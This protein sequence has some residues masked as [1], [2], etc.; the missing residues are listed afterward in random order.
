MKIMQLVRV[1]VPIVLL[2]SG[3]AQAASRQR[4]GMHRPASAT[5]APFVGTLPATTNLD[6]AIGLPLRN[7]EALSELLQGICDPASPLYRQ[8][9][10]PAQFTDRFGPTREDYDAVIAFARAH[11]LTVTATHP[12]RMLLDVRGSVADINNAFHVTL[13]LRRHPTEPRIFFAPDVMPSV[14]LGVP[15]LDVSGLENYALPRPRH[16]ASLLT[17]RTGTS[18]STGSGPYGSYMGEDF[19]AAYVPGSPF[20]G[21]GQIAGLLEFDGYSPAD[22]AYY[23]NKAGL[24]SVTLSNVLLNGVSGNPSGGGGEIEVCLD[25]ELIISMAPGISQLVVYEGANW[26]DILN[27]MAT[28]NVA[29]QISC[30][31]YA[32]NS[33]PD[34]VAD[35][36]WRQMALQGQSFYSASGD[37]DACTGPI[38]F[39]DDSPY[40]TEV[41]GTTLTTASGAYV[42]EKAWNQGNGTGTGG[43]I[44]TSYA[45]PYYQTNI[46]MTTNLGSAVMRNTPDVA[47]VAD[48]LYIRADGEDYSAEGTSASAPLWAGLTALINQLAL[49]NGEPFVGFVNPAVYALG[50]GGRYTSCFHDITVG[51]NQRTGSGA[52]F[53]AT[54]GY[55]LCTGWGTPVGEN[56][57]YALGFPEP[58]HIMPATGGMFT[59][60]VGGPF[61][62]ASQALS[63]TNYAGGSLNWTAG[64]PSLWLNV[65][66]SNGVL[67]AGGPAQTV[68]ITLAPAAT[69]LAAG[70]YQATL[71]FTNQNT[72]FVQSQPVT[73]AVVT[74]PLIVSQP[75]SLALLEG[76]TAI[77]TAGTASN[78]LLNFQWQQD[79]GSVVTNLTD[80]GRISG[81]ASNTLVVS[82]TSPTDQGA[83]SVI[84]SNAAGVA[85]SD[86]AYLAILPWRPVIT[87]QPAGQTV[88][89]G[90]PAAF[91][92]AAVGTHP[93]SYCWQF[94]GTNLSDNANLSGSA[95][96]TLKILATTAAS[97][98][99]Y[100][101]IVS[102][103]LGSTT[104]TAAVL[105]LIPVTGPG[106]NL[107][108]LYSFTN[109]VS[110]AAPYSALVQALDGNFYGTTSQGGANNYG[111]VFRMTPSDTFTT[112]HSFNS[113][114]G[115][116]PY[117]GLLLA[118]DGTLY[119]T[120]S[121][122]GA[123]G[124]GTVFRIATSGAFVTVA[125]FAG[126]NGSYSVA[127]LMQG[128]DG[129]FYGTT[130]YGGIFGL[131]NLF[132]VTSTSQIT[133]LISFD[134]INGAYPSS[135]LVQ[136]SAG[137][138][139]GTAENG[140]ADGWGTVF[141]L[142]LSG[143]FTTL[144]AFNNSNGGVPVPGVVF[145]ADGN[146]YGTTEYGGA[147]GYGTVFKLAPDGSLNTLYSFANRDDGANPYG[148]LLFS[149]DGNL[150]GTTSAGGAYGVGTVFRISTDGSLATLAQLDGYQGAQPAG[151]LVQGRDY[152]LYGTATSGG[153]AGY[154]SVFRL[155][156]SGALQITHQP[157]RQMAY[158]GDTASFDVAIA[159]TMPVSYQWQMNGTNLADGGAISGSAARVLHVA[160]VSVASVGNYS[161]IV[162]NAFGSVT[163]S[164]A[165]LQLVISPPYI[166]KQPADQSLLV[167]ATAVFSVEAVG[168]MPLSYQW[169]KDGID[170]ADGGRISGAT[171]SALTIRTAAET[172]E[173]LYSVV[174]S[175]DW[176]GVQSDNASLSVEPV[177]ASGYTL[178]APLHNFVGGT[179]GANPYCGLIQGQDQVLYGTTENGGLDGYG[180]TYRVLT[181]GTFALLYSF[182]GGNDGASPDAGLAQGTNAMLYGTTTSGGYDSFGTV[183]QVTTSGATVGLYSFTGGSDGGPPLA[184]LVQGSDGNLYGTTYAGGSA[185]LGTVFRIT[186]AGAMT[187]LYSFSGNDGAYPFAALVQGLDGYFYGTTAK[188][189]SNY[190]G[191]IFRMSS[192]GTLT[193]LYTFTGLND[194]A[195]PVAALVQDNDGNFYGTTYEGGNSGFGTVFKIATN[196]TLT[197]LHS[198]NYSDGAHPYAGLAQGSDGNLYGSTELGGL[199]GAGTVFKITTNGA[200]ATII[201]FN[202][203]N[204]A[205]P[206]GT[207][208]QASDSYFY[209]TT[210]FG[211]SANAGLVFRFSIPVAPQI[212]AQPTNLLAF[213]GAN[214]VFSVSATGTPPL[215]YQWHINGTNLTDSGSVAGSTTPTLA[216]TNVSWANA[217]AYSIVVSNPAGSVTSA[218]ASLI[219]TS[220]PPIITLQPTNQ[221]GTPWT[222]PVFT[223]AA[224]G[225]LPLAYQWQ[226][227]GT[228]LSDGDNVLGATTTSLTISNAS[229]KDAGTYSVIVS[230]S[231]GATSSVGAIL[232]V[233]PITALGYAL[234]TIPSFPGGHPNG[235]VPGTNG[236]LYGTTQ[237]GGAN[238]LG[239][240]FQIG[241][242]DAFNTLYSFSGGNDG[243]TPYT[244][245]ARGVDGNY[246]GT[247]TGGG[248]NASGTVFQ[249]SPAGA[250]NSLLS[251]ASGLASGQLPYG[252][253]VQ[254]SDG[255]FYGT[256]VS[257]GSPALA[258]TVFNIT[259]SGAFA[260]L[261]AFAGP[262]GANP[263]AG[264]TRGNDGRFYGTTAFGGTNNNGTVFCIATNGT[265]LTLHSFT[266]GAD[267]GNPYGGLLRGTDG[268]F[269]GTTYAGGSGTNGTVFRLATNGLLATL[270]A[271]GDTNGSG[272]SATLVQDANGL[273]Y[274][275]TETGGLGGV[276]TVFQ[277]TTN[278]L[279]TTLVWFFGP[280]GANPQ[281]ALTFGSDGNLYGT[282]LNGGSNNGGTVFQ[283]TLPR[284]V[285]NVALLL[286]SPGSGQ[287]TLTWAAVAGETFQLQYKPDL[288]STG[289]I[290]LGSPI[291]ATTNLVSASDNLSTNNPRFYRVLLL[292]AGP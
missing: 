44:S 255:R 48:N 238:T 111:T 101:V 158:L 4:L 249:I 239:S 242:T 217:G 224:I 185:S 212:T 133:S 182:T 152:N 23:E 191:N 85:V 13:V 236:S 218:S 169:Q 117:A 76:Q 247:T 147:H 244:A 228:N 188:G 21:T 184:A 32:A 49:A 196:G 264:L 37:S 135:V 173:G 170:L 163:S 269:Y 40:I 177:V 16:V 138:L 74:P 153:S 209:G 149:I 82:N 26:H 219:V 128:T 233:P 213:L 65:T 234:R 60:P 106:V 235:L 246:Y 201:Y 86:P 225:N 62:P 113:T 243:A 77:F 167:G 93:F 261:Y 214:A 129:Y 253:L 8:Y 189:G 126:V 55:D 195:Y 9:L 90:A 151:A 197:T 22:I 131:G 268:G 287:L 36:I 127:G 241:P 168:D 109:G 283:L 68:T 142:A 281:A 17:G 270:F 57:L 288:S 161:V 221:M 210:Y 19:R 91:S 61:A 34:A 200:F 64:N 271:F 10:T 252:A 88:L 39:P 175:D 5:N 45:I 205:S 7:Q 164:N 119:G 42:S 172:D 25:I 289:W 276:G 120:T 208:V 284:S 286:E 54:P 144:A 139:Y 230:N 99:G 216:L 73:L 193:S 72:H 259:P 71:W 203:A 35:Q 157:A 148:G 267:G 266:G 291:T 100:S 81:S 279:F 273:L 75:A 96:T 263:Y 115:A 162:S 143:Q 146:L 254:D 282:T 104:S 199:G 46:D 150:Y 202:G 59:G 250:F 140:G 56:L 174:V 204:G 251:F 50:Q 107:A 2:T 292:P 206:E 257:G 52:R 155:T 178:G 215:S 69:N 29:K 18:P 160:N 121:S 105:S 179:D 166:A 3:A 94:N 124:Q 278:G 30:S 220:S 14:E 258:G 137:N 122:G 274:G 190:S 33:G 78:A 1:A 145:D 245:L 262:D 80:G 207:L 116:T 176:F 6:L 275:S 272:P 125:S 51:N 108:T 265:L 114:D 12:N 27:R 67:V 136:D 134:G 156:L 211:G 103:A 53:P 58:L 165:L 159:G 222:T 171:S 43:G 83:Y 89:P 277:I 187:T 232:S 130:L 38:D 248:T 28:D 240:V 95:T 84:V 102:N 227:A 141:Q 70:A 112:L 31:W 98:G 198:F 41:G 20:N 231:A 180:T 11:G 123:H 63:L 229:S 24:P 132:Q 194:G 87:Q 154:G 15:I 97:A 118:K 92:V 79:N 290:N 285:V 183:F 237:N 256:T 280:N 192:A 226:H 110:G 47:M 260:Q 66:P 186:T 181:N 223:V